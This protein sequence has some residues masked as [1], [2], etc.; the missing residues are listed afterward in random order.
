MIVL[1]MFFS[2][3]KHL[4]VMTNVL[5]LTI[6]GTNSTQVMQFLFTVKVEDMERGRYGCEIT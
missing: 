2:N 6:F 1:V 3:E 4:V 5:S